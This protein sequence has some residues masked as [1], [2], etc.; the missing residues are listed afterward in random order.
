MLKRVV[1]ADAAIFERVETAGLKTATSAKWPVSTEIIRLLVITRVSL[2]MG[3]VILSLF[4][5]DYWISMP[6][7]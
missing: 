2:C 4:Y 1:T 7:T 5:L 3:Q 6:F